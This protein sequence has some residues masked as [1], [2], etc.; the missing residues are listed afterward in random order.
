[1]KR[2][3]VL[4]LGT[5]GLTLV[6]GVYLVMRASREA[7]EGSPQASQ[8]ETAAKIIQAKTVTIPIEGMTCAACVASV[9]KALKAIDGVTATEVSLE[10]RNVRV[11]YLDAKVSPQHLVAAINN[12]G[13]KA[14]T[15]QT[16]STESKR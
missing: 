3:R 15:P 4:L 6:L 12:L 2:K 9:K 14:G 7:H 13:Y 16:S 10:H 8:V 5:L 11:H 1:M